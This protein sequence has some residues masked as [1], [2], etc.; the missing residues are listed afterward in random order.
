MKSTKKGEEFSVPSVMEFLSSRRDLELVVSNLT[1]A[2]ICRYLYSEWAASPE[3]SKE[4]WET[5][6][7]SF[8]IE[9]TEVMIPS[10]SINN[11]SDLCLVDEY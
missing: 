3:K 4:R 2:E 1:R 7:K 6:I 11:I 10:E 5:F 9:Y 8:R